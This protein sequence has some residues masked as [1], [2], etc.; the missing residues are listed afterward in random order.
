M[1]DYPL[2]KGPKGLY[3]VLELSGSDEETRRVFAVDA[4]L[5]MPAAIQI[6]DWPWRS[7]AQKTKHPAISARV[8]RID[9]TRISTT[10]MSSRF[11][12]Y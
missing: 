6:D 8:T 4:A 3:K 10:G 1:T 2:T 7:Q 5:P 9:Q 11:L 12:N